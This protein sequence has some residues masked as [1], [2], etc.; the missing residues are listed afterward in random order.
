MVVDDEVT[1][2]AELSEM[3]YKNRAYPPHRPAIS[4]LLRTLIALRMPRF[5]GP[6]GASV[7]DL[8]AP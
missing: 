8:E 4:G 3:Y 2:V 5:P 7:R 6:F 1:G